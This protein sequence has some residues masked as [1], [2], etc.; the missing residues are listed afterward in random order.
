MVH[1][2][3]RPPTSKP[4]AEEKY[5]A[6]S[7]LS[8]KEI[9]GT[10]ENISSSG[11]DVAHHQAVQSARLPTVRTLAGT[12]WG[13]VLPSGS[14]GRPGSNEAT[15]T[16]GRASET[17]ADQRQ[18][19][20]SSPKDS[21]SQEH[22]VCASWKKGGNLETYFRLELRTIAIEVDCT[23]KSQ[24]WFYDLCKAAVFCDHPCTLD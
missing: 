13:K 19:P 12:M 4:R 23:R 21:P 7:T 6:N 22:G 10:R 17:G 16:V 24:F 8:N 18:P 9:S 3:G 1:K 20:M 2:D 5:L 14:R 15:T 11:V